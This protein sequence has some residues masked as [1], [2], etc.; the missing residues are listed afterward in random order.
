[1]IIAIDLHNIRDGGGVNYIRNLLAEASPVLDGFTA[2][3][4]IG[5]PRLLDAYPDRPWIV[6]HGF[7]A[8]DGS[9]P[10]RL[11]FTC[12]RLPALLRYIGCDI[13]YSPGGLQ[14]G[15]FRPRVTIS[16][17]MMPFR[18]QFW[19]MYRPFS[20]DRLR[21]RL[22]RR[23][24]AATFRDADGVI[25]LSETARHVIASF[26]RHP[27]ERVAIIPHGVD[28]ER[29][30]PL[31]SRPTERPVG[32]PVKL[33]YPSRLEPY[34]HQVEVM[35]AIGRLAVDYPDLELRLC[36][37]ANPT[38]KS[39]FEAALGEV[40]LARGRIAYLGEVPNSALPELYA[41]SDLL[42]FASS[43]ENLPNILIEAMAC[44]IPICCSNRSPMPEISRDACLYFDPA[45]PDSIATAVRA[46]LS[47]WPAMQ[48]RAQRGLAYAEDYS[49]AKTARRTFGFLAEVAG[50]R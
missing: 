15:G 28:R 32:R 9:L 6:K 30:R 22:L 5:A 48:V 42:L 26:V 49:W 47:D 12:T 27:L 25:F 50:A 34:K 40:G 37:P 14:F 31:R 36:G 10:H 38:Y 17:N 20:K 1:M 24:N 21:L 13:L 18:P 7:A 2:V 43:C 39:A 46:A 44:G 19:R 33:V 29:F 35:R 16:R 41:D 3:H 23:L 8:L 4:L 45:D 11:A